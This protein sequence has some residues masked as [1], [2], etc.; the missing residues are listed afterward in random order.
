MKKRINS[1]AAMRHFGEKIGK[2][3]HGGEVI[4]LVGDVGAG[5]TT[6]V[7]GLALGLDIDDTVQSPTFTISRVYEARDG[8]EL[9]HYDFYRLSEPGIM[10]MEIAESLAEPC[11]IVVIEWAGIVEN[12][13][14]ARRLTIEIESLSDTERQLILTAHDDDLK[15]LIEA[16]Q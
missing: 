11:S 14:P 5:K 7:K 12:V 2:H 8:L 16:V 3:L 1:D 4:E 10:A 13:L 9:A 6:F 15:P